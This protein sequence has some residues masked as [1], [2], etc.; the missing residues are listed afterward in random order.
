MSP[1]HIV[2]FTMSLAGM[3]AGLAGVMYIVGQVGFY[4][5]TFGTGIGFD[6]ITVALLGR[7]SPVGVLLAA[8]L[9]GGIR[10]R[11]LR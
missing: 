1:K 6:A 8:M 10:G 9:F 7:G 5:A 4:P 3:L 11:A 2:I